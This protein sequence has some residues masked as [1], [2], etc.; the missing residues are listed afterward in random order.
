MTLGHYVGKSEAQLR[1][2][3]Q[4]VADFVEAAAASIGTPV[5]GADPGEP[6]VG[7][8]EAEPCAP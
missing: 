5:S 3:W 1:A 6:T 7:E 2:G 8:H 4:T